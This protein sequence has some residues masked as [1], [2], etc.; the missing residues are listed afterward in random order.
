MTATEITRRRLLKAALA[1]APALVVP[2]S[3]PGGHPARF[4]SAASSDT[5]EHF[6]CAWSAGRLLFQVPS[7]GRGHDVVV[8]RA[9][10]CALYFARRP[11]RWFMAL[12]ADSG[13]ALAKIH[14]PPGRHFY[15]HGALTKDNRYLFTTEN[16]FSSGRG[17]IGIYDCADRFQRLGE[18][19]SG[20]VGPHQLAMLPDG[21]TLVVANG[22]ILTAPDSSRQ[23]LNIDSMQPSLCYLDRE[24]GA[25]LGEWRP[26]H[27]QLSLRHLAVDKQGT[28]SVG[29]QFEGPPGLDLP[30]LF[31]HKGE[32]QL[33]AFQT[34][35]AVW[36]EHRHYIASVAS[37]EGKVLATSP[38]GNCISL[39]SD[40]RLLERQHLADVAGAAYDV[41]QRQFVTSNGHGQFVGLKNRK[42][43]LNGL[44]T[45]LHWDNHM[46]IAG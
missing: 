32:D 44:A 26:P 16:D 38:R 21:K 41:T 24:S 35:A 6:L 5:G 12:D 33:Q 39:W 2:G 13:E 29:A 23:K 18:F 19:A 7:P 31:S 34:S 8:N 43:H 36:R 4:Y 37:A 15:G 27:H 17:V 30:L 25:L 45:G 9:R 42:L 11:G 46:S 22:G 28:V 40:G 1:S 3:L 20:G 10:H 14:S